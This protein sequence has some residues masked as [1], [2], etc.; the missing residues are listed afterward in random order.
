LDA[1]CLSGLLIF[2]G[3]YITVGGGLANLTIFHYR[4]S[5]MNSLVYVGMTTVG[6]YDSLAAHG[7]NLWSINTK[8]YRARMAKAS[9]LSGY[10][11]S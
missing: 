8:E 6:Y 3:L 11:F 7:P 9:E 2:F 10:G 1:W 5:M 4:L